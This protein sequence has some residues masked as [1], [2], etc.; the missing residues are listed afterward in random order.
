MAG[1]AMSDKTVEVAD[2]V[3]LIYEMKSWRAYRMVGTR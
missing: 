3:F 2:Q 1:N